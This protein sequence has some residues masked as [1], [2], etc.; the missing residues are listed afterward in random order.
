M[1]VVFH[2]KAIFKA[3]TGYSGKKLSPFIILI[4]ICLSFKTFSQSDVCSGV[5]PTLTLGANAGATTAAFTDNT[6]N[7]A[8]GTVSAGCSN[9]NRCS[10]TGWYK[11]TTGAQGGNLTISMTV[12][13]IRYGSMSLYSGSCG[14][15]TQ[16]DCEDANS[17]T[18]T[19]APPNI[20]ASCLSPNTTYYIMVWS[21][22]LA[23]SNYF[24]TFTLTTTFSASNDCCNSAYTLTT[25][26]TTGTTTA[27][28]TNT[29]SDPVPTCESGAGKC[30]YTAWYAYT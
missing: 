9:D 1:K 4:F 11:Y 29:S 20:T 10:Y 21:D 13:T 5:V 24:G 17:V 7:P 2:H 27:S 3:F 16:I 28:Y 25:G 6:S 22:G 19:V 12:G 23:A 14:S 8:T 26:A 30:N 15:F 18:S